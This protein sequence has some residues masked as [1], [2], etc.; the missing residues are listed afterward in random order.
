MGFVGVIELVDEDITS[1][2]TVVKLVMKILFND[3]PTRTIG[4]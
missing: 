2:N 3:G 1:G 4:W